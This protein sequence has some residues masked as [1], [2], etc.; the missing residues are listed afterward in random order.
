MNSTLRDRTVVD[1]GGLSGLMGL[2]TRAR[3]A[4]FGENACLKALRNGE[5]GLLILDETISD[6]AAE[7]FE[8]A[9]KPK[10]IPILWLEDGCLWAATGKPGMVMG[11]RDSGFAERMMACAAAGSSADRTDD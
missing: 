8:S 2:C 6:S 11:V 4:V 7:K 9:A 3:Q 1:S 5:I 10:S